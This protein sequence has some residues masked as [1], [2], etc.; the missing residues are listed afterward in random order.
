MNETMKTTI[1]TTIKSF[2]LI[3]LSLVLATSCDDLLEENPKYGLNSTV[4]FANKDTAEVVLLGIYSYMSANGGYGQM[5]QEVPLCFSGLTWGQRQAN[6]AGEMVMLQLSP[7][8]SEV[9]MAWKGMYKVISEANAF[10]QSLDQG[11]LSDE[12]N[13]Q[14]GG[15]ARFLRGLAYYNLGVAFGGVPLK[16]SASSSDGISSTRATEE[17]IFNQ[18]VED[19]K[20]AAENLSTSSE[21]GR[22]N[23]WTA[24]AYLGK[25][26]WRMAMLGYN[27]TENL[28]NAK[29]YFD[30]VYSSNVYSLQSDYAAMF[31]TY[32]TGCSESIFQLN[33]STSAGSDSFNRGS[34][35]FGPTSSTSGINWGTFR[36]QK[37]LYDLHRGTYRD[38]GR[39]DATY[40]T[41]WRSRD[42][43]NQTEPKAQ[44]GSELCANDSSYA[45]PYK[46]YT[47]KET[48]PGARRTKK[49]KAVSIPYDEL[50]NPTNPDTAWLKNYRA[51]HPEMDTLIT[52][53]IA[54]MTS[55]FT[56]VGNAEKWPYFA[57]LYDQT[58]TGQMSHKNLIVY[59]YAEML[60]IMAD[61]YNELGNTA[62]AV[63]L[64]NEVLSR[65]RNI[66][67]SVQPVAWSTSL[68]QSE[69]R[70]KLYFER[71]FELSGEPD[72]FD[73]TRCKGTEYLKKLLNYNNIH[74]FTMLSDSKYAANPNNFLDYLYGDNG[75]L[76]ESFLK[77]VMHM[78]IPQ[79]EIDGNPGLSNEDQ[80]EGY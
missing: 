64:A 52:K 61:V 66:N 35:R 37:Y 60:L 31:G 71:L 44:V 59:R 1:K 28:N 33:F 13:R 70:E 19:I 75:T 4:V 72:A 56:A 2:F 5:W 42:G 36:V 23:S 67:A 10:M 43:N 74:E 21:V 46:T 27:T 9:N 17:E 41:H 22:A 14:F 51:A 24:K 79:A 15:E 53:T 78:P 63:E 57:K 48:V 58:Q 6:D 34:N 55:S 20:Y 3:A 80:N 26:Y 45:Y 32:V 25:V 18:V 50:S 65:A 8:N 76:T 30:E 73:M 16:L 69:V 7:S 38:D 62:R 47:T 54:N 11:S 29:N 68:T 39:L 77:K 12:D 49:M 40:L